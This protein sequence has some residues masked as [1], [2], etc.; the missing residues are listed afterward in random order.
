MKNTTQRRSSLGIVGSL[1]VIVWIAGAQILP[2][3][4][5]TKAAPAPQY[6]GLSVGWQ[7]GQGSLAEYNYAV[8]WRTNGGN[9]QWTN[10]VQ[11]NL[12][13]MVTGLVRGVT[14]FFAVE[15]TPA[16][17]GPAETARSLELQWR[18]AVTNWVTVSLNRTNSS[19]TWDLAMETNP[20]ARFWRAQL[21]R[22]ASKAAT[23]AQA[24]A[25]ANLKGPWTPT[26]NALA[27]TNEPAGAEYKVALRLTNTLAWIRSM[28]Q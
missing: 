16:G 28:E 18:P 4:P 25:A 20:P 19:A 13:C 12:S 27:L 10:R 1:A 22:S 11:T 26:G 2:T 7:P 6:Y 5:V 23:N 15:A 17:G 21:K 3:L 8:T 24:L 9:F 14:Y